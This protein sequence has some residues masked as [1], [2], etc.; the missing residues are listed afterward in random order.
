MLSASTTRSILDEIRHL[1][2]KKLGQN[3]LIDPNIVRKSLELAKLVAGENVVE[4]GP[5]LGT[6]TFSLL[7]AG[8]SVYAVEK[9]PALYQRLKDI[10]E[11]ES[12]GDFD[13]LSGDAV[14]FPR[15]NFSER[16]QPFKIVANLPYAVTTPWM[17]KILDGQLPE[18]MVLMVQKEAADRL[19]ASVGTK[20][21]SAI[22]IALHAAYTREKGHA[23]SK[24]CFHPAPKVDSVYFLFCRSVKHLIVFQQRRRNLFGRFLFIGENKFNLF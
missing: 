16:D 1:P 21:F 8:C 6:L 4:V 3:F 5:G 2:N 18:R 10:K 19:T 14:E 9:D 22:S 20:H 17:D 15:A 13:L 23:V 24:G 12:I 7:E 11:K